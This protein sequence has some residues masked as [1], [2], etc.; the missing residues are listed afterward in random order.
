MVLHA[1]IVRGAG[2]G[3]DKTVLHSAAYAPQMGVRMAAAYLHPPRDDGIAYIRHRAA[4][5]G[6]PLYTIADRG[7]VDPWAVRALV[8][9][10]RRLRVTLWHAHDYKTD[11]LGLLIRR[12]WPMRLVT[13]VHGFT[14][15]TLRTRLYRRLDQWWLRQYDQVIAVSPP[16]HAQCLN[17]GVEPERLNYVPN[18]IDV[19]QFSSTSDR[20]MV[21][22]E[23]GVLPDRLVIGCIGRLSPEKGVDRALHTVARL[24]PWHPRLE[25]HLVG[26][27]PERRRLES[28]AA[29]LNIE[30]HVHFWGWQANPKRFYEMLDLLLLPSHTEGLPN[31]VL[32]AMAMG[33]PVASTDTG[34]IAELL[35]GGEAGLLLP[36]KSPEQW[37]VPLSHLLSSEPLRA[38]L[39]NHARVRVENHY[40]FDARMDRI[41]G[42]YRRLLSLPARPAA[43]PDRRAA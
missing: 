39:A 12:F 8:H 23:L 4:E 2:G 43:L 41:A 21:R 33:V 38:D 14:D 13:T 9:L 37:L 34:G 16:L 24:R 35:D 11:L 7:P 15:E 26:D 27:G 28:L 18:A 29:Q 17:A 5:L 22:Y 31:T 40:S 30:D 32:E 42:V 20:E 36:V 1:R 6:C 10:C 19:E 25:L 3:P